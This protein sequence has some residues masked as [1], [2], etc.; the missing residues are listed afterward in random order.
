[1][2]KLLLSFIVAIVGILPSM[3]QTGQ[4][5]LLRFTCMSD[6]HNQQSMISQANVDNI[7]LRTAFLNT[8]EALKGNRPDLIVLGGDYT[9]DVTIP[10]Q[11]WLKV[12]QLMHEAT[13]AAVK[14]SGKGK[15]PVLYCNGNHEY[16]VANFDALPKPYNAGDYYTYP[17]KDELGELAANECFYETAAN[18]NSASVR[19]LAAY[20]YVIGGFDFVV[21]NTGKNFFK[22]A[23][24]YTYSPESVEWVDKKLDEIYANDPQKTVFFISHLP[25]AGSVGATV[26]KTISASS[27][28]N[29]KLQTALAKHPNLIAIYGHDHSSNK[30]NSFYEK[31]ITQR[32][33]HYDTK[34]NIYTP[35]EETQEVPTEIAVD[36]Q[37]VGT[38][39]YLGFDTN[40]LGLLDNPNRFVVKNSTAVDNTLSFFGDNAPTNGNGYIYCG[41]GGRFSGNQALSEKSSIYLYEMTATAESSWTGTHVTTIEDGKVYAIV[42][43][44]SA[45]GYYA[46]KAEMYNPGS[47]GQ[48]MTGVA[49][50]NNE[51]ITL[52]DNNLLWTITNHAA[53]EPEPEVTEGATDFYIQDA[54]G[55][56]F[57]YNENM[58]IVGSDIALTKGFKVTPA[59]TTTAP[60]GGTGCVNLMAISSSDGRYIHCGT[61]GKF[62]GNTTIG[63]TNTGTS[64]WLYEVN[65]NTAT[66]VAAPTDG[67][68]YLIIGYKGGAFYQMT[69]ENNGAATNASLRELS[70]EV[71]G[72]ESPGETIAFN[73]NQKALW[74]FTVVPE[75]VAEPSFMSI[76]MGS[77]RYNNLNSNSSPGVSDSPIIQALD[78]TV[79]SD[80]IVLEIKNYGQTGHLTGSAVSPT[81][82]EPLAPYVIHR[83]VTHSESTGDMVNIA[84][85]LKKNGKEENVYNVEGMRLPVKPAQLNTMPK[86]VYVVGNK[87]VM[88]K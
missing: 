18:G 51:T 81:L 49:A 1:M 54:D 61:G 40:N 42:T 70:E 19:L 41:S 7:R 86:G 75:V 21:L 4:G 45:G 39:K 83:A 38:G 22:S 27:E 48:R 68:D 84:T 57:D 2:R 43:K 82:V 23:W 44:S 29:A 55:N 53:T 12:R 32:I 5:P 17:M 20:H 50:S 15:H 56:Y 79:Y 71:A 46:L 28:G 88:V 16:E 66:R 37:S 10:E 36:I 74:H 14:T 78:V 60:W 26:G 6:I 47:T 9:S 62:S 11:N 64:L 85:P 63:N 87:K 65:G 13:S 52:T 8:L 80:S 69:N 58:K 25:L 31:S 33:T 35:E 34:G 24:D 30:N 67:K 72:M 73:G 76:F 59:T 3:A 77:M